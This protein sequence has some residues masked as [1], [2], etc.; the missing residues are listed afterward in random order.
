MN[1]D[2]LRPRLGPIGP[3]S[4]P[5]YLCRQEQRALVSF[6]ITCKDRLI[7][8]RQTLPRNLAWHQDDAEV[9][10]VIVN[11]NSGDELQQ[12]VQDE[13]AAELASGRIVHYF[14][15]EPTAFHASHAKNQAFR[16]ARGSILC[17]L[18]A[19]NFTGPGFAAYVREQ[20]QALDF[21]SGGV[22]EGDRIV[23]TNVRGV[24]GRNVVPRELFWALGGFDEQFSSWGYE[25]SNLSER[26]MALGLKGRL[27]EERYL[28]CID[29][30]DELRTRHFSNKVTGRNTGR[31]F[32]SCRDNYEIWLQKKAGGSVVCAPDRFGCGTVYRNFAS[33]PLVLGLR[34]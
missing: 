21:L 4:I 29:H 20:L 24:E 15:P 6:C 34:P 13:C 23:A 14:N 27:I 28:S 22:I 25:D 33:E 3:T 30:G 18:D 7:H 19:D 12:W 31:A 11:Y 26:M 10:F 1:D 16:L 32:G 2:A 8:L 17:N 5:P 9:E